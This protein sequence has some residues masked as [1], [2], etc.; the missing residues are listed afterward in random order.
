MDGFSTFF[1]RHWAPQKVIDSINEA[2]A[3][4]LLQPGSKNVYVG[5][6]S[7]GVKIKMR[8][9]T[10]GKIAMAFPMMEKK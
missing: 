3:N 5:V 4:K 2:F 7:E 9:S 6:C 1:P 10:E 8:L